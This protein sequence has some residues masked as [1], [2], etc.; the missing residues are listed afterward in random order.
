MTHMDA[1]IKAE[2]LSIGTVAVDPSLLPPLPSVSTAGPGVG[3]PSVFFSSGGLRV[4]LEVNPDSPLRMIPKNGHVVITRD[5]QELVEGEIEEVGAHCPDQVYITISERCIFDCLFCSVPKSRGKIKSIEEILAIVEKARARGKLKVI[6]L[7]SGIT[8]SPEDEI[9]RVVE[10]VKALKPYRVPIGVAVHP[11]RGS[12]QKLK[13]AGV[14]EVK[15]SV[16]TMD[17]EIFERV[18][19]G[20]KGDSL[21]FILESLRDAVRVFGKN[22]VSSNIIIGLGET[23]EG[24]HQGV[25]TLA[26]MGVISVLRPITISP[27]RKAD[28]AFA[29]RPSAERLLKLIRMTR[30][31]LEKY[32]LHP[33]QS[34]TMCLSC[35]G[36]DLTPFRDW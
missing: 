13:D 9:D 30:A 36:C 2:L 10:V 12:S 26:A 27:Q 16:E 25:E 23:D 5:H 34:R 22:Q 7:T 4:R 31:I 14:T 33:E 17:P 3:L 28:L 18:C 19:R 21:E 15:Y 11:A 1:R 6:A 32:D 20:R 24:V 29:R 8:K 35:T